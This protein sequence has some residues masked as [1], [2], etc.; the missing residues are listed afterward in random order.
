M[1]KAL[2]EPILISLDEVDPPLRELQ[3]RWCKSNLPNQI[4]E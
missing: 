3:L 1:T 2:K 4:G